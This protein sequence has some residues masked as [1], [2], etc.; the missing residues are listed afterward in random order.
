MQWQDADLPAT[1]TAS[2]AQFWVALEQAGPWG[3]E[4]ITASHLDA[5]I[6][7]AL[8]RSCADH[9]GR[10][11]L[12]RE[13]GPHADRVAAQGS[14]RVFIAGG[15]AT[16]PWLLEGEVDDP[17][18][19]LRL[20][21]SLLTGNDPDA[22]TAALPELEESR[23]PILLVCTNGR[24][25]VCCAVRGR[26][27]ALTAATSRPGRVWE[28]SHTGGHRFAPTGIVLPSGQTWGRLTED[29]ALLA[30]AAERRGEIPAE[31]NAPSYDRGRSCVRP[32]A[33]AAISWVR[34]DCGE[35]RTTA[36]RLEA[37]EST[38]DAAA[39]VSV[40][41]QDGRVWSLRVE[42][43]QGPLLKDSCAKD[44]KP[45]VSWRVELAD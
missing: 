17:A 9:D 6:G 41:H 33:Q 28:C 40:S 12:I 37:I 11:L 4:A 1:G 3:R 35:L 13:P 5:E 19:L 2:Y 44:P 20:P 16:D 24:R 38:H 22:V 34:Q 23:D 29:T 42:R 27:V 30:L 39:L 31:L 32:E 45:A 36:L 43:S 10:L 7:A 15:L 18:D 26:P 8:E 14:S 21:W 25:D